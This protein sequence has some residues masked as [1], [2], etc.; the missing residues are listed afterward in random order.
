MRKILPFMV[1]FL[2]SAICQNVFAQQTYYWVGGTN[3]SYASSSSWNVNKGGGGQARTSPNAGD[4]LIIDG[5]DV[6]GGPA[7]TVA[8]SS[9]SNE[10]ISQLQITGNNV[11]V[12]FATGAGAAGAGTIAR[13]S[14]SSSVTGSGTSFTS[15]FAVGDF[16]YTSVNSNLSQIIAITNDG[17]LT[18]G[19]TSSTAIT[20]GTAY[21]RANMLK[22]T[23][24]TAALSISSG[25]TLSMATAV[26]LVVKL[27]AGA[28]ATINGTVSFNA[29]AQRLIS[30]DS[31]AITFA[32]GSTFIAGSSFSGNAFS[33]VAN[34]TNDN[35][36][37]ADGSTYN[38]QGGSNP[39]AATA[40]ASV[41]YFSD[42]SNFLVNAGSAIGISG[43]SYGN[44]VVNISNIT[45]G[46]PIRLNNLT[47]N[48]GATFTI[49]T[50]SS[51][52]ISGN[53]TLTGTGSIAATTLPRVVF[54]G[55]S[56]NPQ[57]I[58]IGTGTL[59]SLG[60]IVVAS[61]ADVTLNNSITLAPTS[62][63]NSFIS[64]KL[65]VGT[66]TITGNANVTFRPTNA[67]SVSTTGDLTLGSQT[68]TNVASTA[69]LTTGFTVS[70]TG[71]PAGTVVIGTGVG[72]ITIS[73][74]PTQAVT[75]ATLTFYTNTSTIVTSNTGGIGGMLPSV[76][77]ITLGA[78]TSYVF[79]GATTTPFP[80]AVTATNLT[81][82]ANVTLNNTTTVN[83]TLLANSGT[84][85]TNGNLIIGS[86][87]TGTGRIG[88]TT[89][90]ISGNVTVQRYIPAG[91][92]G[93]RFLS[94]AVTTITTIK[95]NWQE[96]S[97]SST[98][99]P[100]PGFGTHITGSTVDQTNG[101]DGTVT[102]NPSLFQFINSSQAWNTG[103]TNTNVDIL[104]AGNA[105]RLLIRGS[106]SF[107]LTS[108]STTNTAT[109]L[110]ATGA[111]TSG[112]VTMNSSGAGAT[113]GMPLLAA[114]ANQFSFIGNP[115]ASPVSWTSVKAASTD[116]TGYY[117]IWDPTLATRGAYVS[118]F[119]D[120]TKNNASSNITTDIQSGQAFFVQ[121][122]A[123]ITTGPVV[124][125]QEAH[126]TAG[127]TNVFRNLSTNSSLAIQLF[128]AS[129]AT[130]GG[131]SQD[132]VIALFNS[133][134]Q[135]A[136]NDADASKMTNQ[137]ENIAISQQGKNLSIEQRQLPL[138]NETIQLQTWQLQNT[139]YTLRIAGNN[140]AVGMD[141]YLKDAY[142]NTETLLNLNGSTDVNFSVNADAA[143]SA[144]N[145]FSIV[146][147]ANGALPVSFTGIKAYQKN[148][149]I[150]VDWNVGTE[151]NISQYEVEKS[152]DAVSFTMLSKVQASGNITYTAVDAS[153]VN[154][155]NFYRIKAV[156]K[157]GKLTYSS[158]VNVKLSKEIAIHV[159]GNPIMNKQLQLQLNNVDK[160]TY[161]I[162]IF[163]GAGAEVARTSF[164]H[165]GGSAT[166]SIALSELAAGSYVVR[167]ISGNNLVLSQS[168]LIQ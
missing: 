117:Y 110:R 161:Q 75:G 154:G 32:N 14:N 114:S 128:L 85:T 95:A 2:A 98:N 30:T 99:D 127:N 106:R 129:N 96:A 53:I 145:R 43:R 153:P 87:S 152:F 24:A 157:S 31:K 148:S 69:G 160:G 48:T 135:N 63:V 93:F 34:S 22:L 116:I 119:T 108:T 7:T 56:A 111:I 44:L 28:K 120:G 122:N 101:F 42:A 8:V 142:A 21:S 90:A 103:A 65:T 64:G 151:V 61:D 149:A 82:N 77:T 158:V 3:A 18:T 33:V 156:D 146:F 4:V 150:Q 60:G 165:A 91:K 54:C 104:T 94:P 13:A 86:N 5:T 131:V 16:I 164:T 66:N 68:I 88:N 84:L 58:T 166:N 139:N 78:G 141:A 15:F 100:N 83:G 67:S 144:A 38:Y 163:N 76:G 81:T 126:K 134:Y 130:N 137:D 40:P 112:Q 107:D 51:F 97:T 9:V 47:V 102:G 109:T 132:G 155:N 121:N 125:F 6:G 50:T 133:S 74:L 52:P 17:A 49:S 143:S 45:S 80:S 20:A 105:Y 70:G 89:G 19:E 46:A 12:S 115:Y 36:A 136:V 11:T 29:T 37:F 73:K 79:N 92:R 72:T 1:L 26:P 55:T 147:R 138:S 39:F 123:S 159:V 113:A 62:A 23:H 168:I 25:C 27:V 162:A 41:T 10:T 35:I 167:V 118:C 124:V 140:F 71:I 59:G 57:S